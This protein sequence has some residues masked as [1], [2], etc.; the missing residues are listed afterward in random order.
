MRENG[1]CGPL[2]LADFFTVV[3]LELDDGSA[4]AMWVADGAEREAMIG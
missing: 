2:A 4:A 1:T 3:A